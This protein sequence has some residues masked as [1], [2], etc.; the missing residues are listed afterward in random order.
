MY[1]IIIYLV[2][3]ISFYLTIS[4]VVYILEKKA[5]SYDFVRT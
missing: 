4:R 5:I 2:S 3:A 1:K